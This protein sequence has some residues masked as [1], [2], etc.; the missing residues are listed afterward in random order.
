MSVSSAVAVVVSSTATR[1]RRE[2]TFYLAAASLLLVIVAMGFHKFYAHGQASDGGPVTRRIAPFVVLHGVLMSSWIIA[3]VLQSGLIVG[4]N[5]KLHM[6]LGVGGAV[7]ATLLVIVGMST[8]IASVHYNPESYKNIWGA[9]RFLSFMLTNIS[10]F[11]VLAGIGLKYR[12]R[13]EVHRPMM[14]LA[15][16][17]V[18]GPAGFFRIPFISGLIMGAIHTILAP[19]VPMLVVGFLLVLIKW[20]MTGS[21]DRYFAAGFIGIVL[22]CALQFFV[23]N[24]AW[25]YQVA[26]WVTA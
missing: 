5:R 26:G 16:L 18:A 1:E 25:W 15:T 8:A 3:L 23:A 12:L 2:R 22:A 19:W 9:R 24:S 4:G 21:W 20:L 7:L 6:S 13:P 11:G 17:F 14:L 10:G